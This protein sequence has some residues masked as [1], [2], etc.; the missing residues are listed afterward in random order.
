MAFM[1]RTIFRVL[2]PV[3]GLLGLVVTVATL[4]KNDLETTC[5]GIVVCVLFLGYFFFPDVVTRI[6][7]EDK[8]TASPKKDGDKKT[9]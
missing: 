4:R 8:I 6:V 9:K 7:A 2:A 1:R 5:T 3:I